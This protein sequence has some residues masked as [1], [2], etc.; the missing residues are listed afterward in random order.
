MAS[1]E[2]NFADYAEHHRHP[3]NK[4]THSFGIPLIAMALLGLG[5]RITLITLSG[6]VSIDL[7]LLLIVVVVGLYLRW[8]V[9][10]A[11]GMLALSLLLYAIGSVLGIVTL[12]VLLVVGLALQYIGHIVFEGRKP[13]FHENAVHMLI[14]PLWMA[15]RLF[16]ALGLY[17]G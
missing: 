6:R 2:E 11:L 5:S 14:G 17:R 4:A 7:G 3:W 8:H 12:I 10:L 15:A 1:L 9:G 16:R 13:A